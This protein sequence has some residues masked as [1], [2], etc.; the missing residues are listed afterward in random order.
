MY[1]LFASVI[2]YNAT[3]SSTDLFDEATEQAKSFFSL[4]T[5]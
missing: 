5:F 4:N 2:D 3:P 1:I